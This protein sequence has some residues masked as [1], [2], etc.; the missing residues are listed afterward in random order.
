TTDSKISEHGSDKA[1]LHGWFETLSLQLKIMFDLSCHDLPPI[2]EDNLAS[3]S[4][5]LHKYL[6]YSNPILDTDDD[7]EVS[8]VD[9]VKAD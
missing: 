2:F 6:N 8:V 5:L 9:T 3:I 4:E 1:L 7:T